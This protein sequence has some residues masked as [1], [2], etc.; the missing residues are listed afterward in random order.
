ME[1]VAWKIHT[2]YVRI[3][4][5][6]V[7]WIINKVC[8]NIFFISTDLKH[9]DGLGDLQLPYIPHRHYSISP[10]TA[11]TTTHITSVTSCLFLAVT[12]WTML[13][14]F[15]TCTL[16]QWFLTYTLLQ[17]FLTYT[18]L[19]CQVRRPCWW[20]R[21]SAPPPSPDIYWSSGPRPWPCSHPQQK[22]AVTS[23]CQGGT[24]LCWNKKTQP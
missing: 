9:W 3:F 1:R 10:P 2:D 18:L 22:K 17:W 24:L 14:W 20:P 4:Y 8:K 13:V 16:L 5:L 6:P 19:Y 7:E 21:C 15:L 12:D 23:H 11:K